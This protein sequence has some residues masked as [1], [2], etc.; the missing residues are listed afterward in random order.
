[1]NPEI[2]TA[3][4]G[5]GLFLLGMVV[6]T[7]GLRELA[8]GALR[9][10]LSRFTKTPVRG[11]LAGAFATAVVQSSSATT[12]T[13]VGFVG[14]GLLTFP[15]GLGI[16]FGA[17]IGTTITGWL[18][19][20]VGFKLDL[21]LA[22]LPLV[23]VGVM[24]RLFAEGRLR[25]IG[26]ALAGFALLF[27]G[28]DAM[29]QGLGRFEGVLT[30]ADFPNDTVTGR[31]L[32][33]A[34]G[35]AITLVT[36]SSSAGV[37]TA[38]VALD[39]GSI[40]FAQ[41]A[42]MVVG[43]DVGTTFT[44]V[45]AT[46]GGSTASRRTGYAHVVYNVMTAVLALFLLTPF[47][48]FVEPRITGA[49][50]AQIALVAFHSLFNTLGVLLVLPVARPFARMIVRIV[51]ERGPELLA[52]LDERLLRDPAAAADA[53]VATLHKIACRL[54]AIVGELVGREGGHRSHTAAL[55]DIDATLSS[56]AGYL[57]QVRSDRRD[58]A[59]H[60]RLSEAMLALDHLQRLSHRCTQTA[61]ADVLGS[62]TRL[63][64]LAGVLADAL[65]QL[66]HDRDEQAAEVRFD[67]I[68][69][70]LRDQRHVVRERTVRA[71]ARREIDAYVTLARLDSVR[72]LHRVAYH[73]WRILAHM[74]AADALGPDEPRVGRDVLDIEED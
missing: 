40:S 61:R 35:I 1:M 72:W 54:F 25:Q 50:D 17:N 53:A 49:G 58:V 67:R 74:R 21:G 16:V 71:T 56:V 5:L 6:L 23:L 24:L 13:A 69:R 41:S 29:Q 7:D 27:V 62:D 46:V 66:V 2:L 51:P 47:A 65:A 22:V 60:R 39:S 63:R 4:G 12:V 33:V 9:R 43:M 8:G 59:A 55:T 45:L 34:I 3:V 10:F 70:L 18:V 42:A 30:P 48:A 19:A 44:A 14:A 28:I 64:R 68:R 37:A 31:L 20:I 15:Q 73:L 52:R 26:F 32:L 57:E 11:A 36:Q 38:L